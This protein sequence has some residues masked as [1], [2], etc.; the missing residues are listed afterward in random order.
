MLG[1]PEYRLGNS[2]RVDSGKVGG[3]R[4]D[5]LIEK[6]ELMGTFI[7]GGNSGGPIINTN[8]EVIGIAAKGLTSSGTV[9]SEFIPIKY[10]IDMLKE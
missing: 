7:Y 8:N 3:I 6:N 2:I 1:Y 10:V 5:K 9:P 4:Y